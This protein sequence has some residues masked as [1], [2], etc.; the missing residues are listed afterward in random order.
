MEAKKRKIETT[1]Q[2]DVSMKF[3][4]LNDDVIDKILSKLTPVDLCS[5]SFVNKRLQSLA[6]DNF[7]R[8]Y[9][10]TFFEIYDSKISDGDAD[11]YVPRFTPKYANYF[12]KFIKNIVI[13]VQEAS[14]ADCW[15][16]I[17]EEC[18]PKLK[19][20]RITH[21]GLV[22]DLKYSGKIIKDQLS[23]IQ[24]IDIQNVSSNDI[25]NLHSG[26]LQYCGEIKSL[27]IEE[28]FAVSD[29]G[30]ELIHNYPNL[31]ELSLSGDPSAEVGTFRGLEKFIQMNPQLEK[32]DVPSY[33]MENT[34]LSCDRIK[35][36]RLDFGQVDF[37]TAISDAAKTSQRNKHIE[38]FE[39]SFGGITFLPEFNK[40]Q[41][42]HR[43]TTHL[44]RQD[45]L[46][47]LK[48][49]QSL[50]SLNLY[51][52]IDADALRL[53][54]LLTGLSKLPFLESLHLDVDKRQVVEQEKFEEII[55]PLVRRSTKLAEVS[56]Y[57]GR[58][59]RGDRQ[60]G[61]YSD[62]GTINVAELSRARQQ[63]ERA[64]KMT[65]TVY[66]PKPRPNIDNPD[67][68]IVK[69]IVK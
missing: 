46:N 18:S 47:S 26:L 20:L 42:I 14:F 29:Y 27:H 32:I 59:T 51:I 39:I 48:M 61:Q 16:L 3:S 40:I 23:S 1:V 5:M 11:R 69:I 34:L 54:T 8:K 36:L 10:D 60:Y 17:K 63:V 7:S 53:Q 24:S 50:Q 2:E 28:C 57:F 62:F 13:E 66:L 52:F 45:D 12:S 33:M 31:T 35:S 38:I 15:K 9:R 43:L 6:H 41:P 21:L 58:Y 55:E 37:F 65:F 22:N 19:S 4:D 25:N 30:K 44:L 67:G 68:S 64:V 49:L 56:L